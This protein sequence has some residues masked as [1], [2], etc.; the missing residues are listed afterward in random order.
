MT[1]GLRGRSR[2]TSTITRAPTALRLRFSLDDNNGDVDCVFFMRFEV[3]PPGATAFEALASAEVIPYWFTRE[4]HEPGWG[5]G[6][7]C[8][9]KFPTTYRDEFIEMVTQLGEL[10]CLAQFG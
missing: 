4:G 2:P 7:R 5:V 1:T 8:V 3:R 10:R 9:C 6:D